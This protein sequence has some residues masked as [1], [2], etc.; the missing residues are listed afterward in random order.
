MMNNSTLL[1]PP[2]KYIQYYF[3]PQTKNKNI[4]T[5]VFTRFTNNFDII[6]KIE[7]NTN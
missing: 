7:Y 1:L 6:L 4:Y 5:A 2:I 3:I